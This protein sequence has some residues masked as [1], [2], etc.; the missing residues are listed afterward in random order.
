M[1]ALEAMSRHDELEFDDFDDEEDEYDSA[2]WLYQ[3]LYLNN[4]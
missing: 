1:D 4:F 2:R 3:I